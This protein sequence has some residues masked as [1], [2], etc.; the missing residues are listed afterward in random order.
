MPKRPLIVLAALIAGTAGVAAMLMT[1]PDSGTPRGTG[2]AAIAPQTPPPAITPGERAGAA[3]TADPDS[4]APEA[5][6][7][8]P[9]P[10]EPTTR[11]PARRQ[12]A[13]R[14]PRDRGAA[15]LT[16]AVLAGDAAQGDTWLDDAV[17]RGLDLARK[18]GPLRLIQRRA[19]RTTD[20]GALLDEVAA[21]SPALVIAVGASYAEPIRTASARHP[22]LRFLLL[23]AELPGEAAVKSVTF[24]GAEGGFLAGVA[25]AAETQRGAVAMIGAMSSPAL[26][27]FECAWETGVRWGTKEAFRLVR[28]VVVYLGTTPEAFAQPAEAE[29]R[30]RELIEDR[31]VDVIIAAAGGSGAGVLEAA[32]HARIKAIGVDTEP[33]DRTRDVVITSIRK[34]ADRIVDAVVADVR[35]GTF[36]GG[37]SVMNLANAGVEIASPGR[38]APATRKL[39]EKARAGIIAGRVDVCVKEED[40]VPAWNFPPRPQ[41]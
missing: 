18:H 1:R 28:G 19:A 29:A 2:P 7:A 26:D 6:R 22:R 36:R 24:R 15:E 39:V 37:A 41:G 17:D 4:P 3:H 27:A 33:G 32:R 11:S 38:L 9:S 40:R 12:D 35:R 31:G 20:P 16:V 13:V 23:D 10:G 21:E 8:V 30:S 25:A 14:T 5:A 34:R